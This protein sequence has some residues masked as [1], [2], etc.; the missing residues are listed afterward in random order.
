MAGAER[1]PAR[2]D[3]ID[4]SLLEAGLEY[5]GAGGMRV[6]V[7]ERARSQGRTG[8]KDGPKG[9]PMDCRFVQTWT[10][11]EQLRPAATDSGVAGFDTL[12]RDPDARAQFGL[13]PDSESSGR[14][15]HQI[16]FGGQRCIWGVGTSDAAR[17]D[18]RR[19]RP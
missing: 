10:A 15:Q 8:E 12:A 16:R 6:V 19:E 17:F 4:G 14:R 3:G 11:A 13:Q 5:F 9:Q 7:G 18:E 2:R 1:N